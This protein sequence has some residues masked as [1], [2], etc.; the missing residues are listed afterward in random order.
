MRLIIFFL[1]LCL[2]STV[3]RAS[4][5]VVTVGSGGNF[6]SPANFTINPGDT[7]RWVWIDGHHNVSGYSL[8]TGAPT[9][10]GDMTFLDTVFEYVPVMSGLYQYTC[11][12][13]S[14]MDGTFFVS[15]CSYPSKPIVNA[16]SNTGCTGDTLTLSVPSQAGVTYQWLSNGFSIPF[17][18]SDS[19]KVGATGSY[20]VVVNRC[21]MD[22]I[23]D[24][25]PVII[26]DPP[27]ASFTHTSD[28]LHFIFNSTAVADSYHWTF[29]DGSP[30][31]NTAQA[32]IT[33]AV[34]DAYTV[35]LKTMNFGA[36]CSDSFTATVIAHAAVRVES[37]E[38][39]EVSVYPNPA[40]KVIRVCCEGLRTVV[41]T[42]MYGRSYNLPFKKSRLLN[43]IKTDKLPDGFYSIRLFSDK[44][45]YK[46]WVCIKH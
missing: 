19:L 34:P 41:V 7:V 38:A 26:Q 25:F 10:Y 4:L 33:F 2:F 12:H 8:P 22:S 3:A 5:V 18:N 46:V 9:L 17:A 40:D 11:T 42:D 14:G 35:S 21:G 1:Y 32:S 6:F 31:Q 37:P 20:K 36:A 23:S 39:R 15:G 29:S 30:A 16:N 27:S 44:N 45:I 24:A 43:D 28:G 13:H